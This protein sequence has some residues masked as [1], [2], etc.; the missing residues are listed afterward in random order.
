M[1]NVFTYFCGGGFLAG[2]LPRYAQNLTNYV[3]AKMISVHA[4]YDSGGCSE[5][6]KTAFRQVHGQ[7]FSPG[8]WLTGLVF[9]DAPPAENPFDDSLYHAT[10]ALDLCMN[11]AK[12]FTVPSGGN[13][14]DVV[15]NRIDE[16]KNLPRFRPSLARALTEMAAAIDADPALTAALGNMQTHKTS[17]GNL[18]ILY[19][20]HKYGK[21]LIAALRHSNRLLN[22]AEKTLAFPVGIDDCILT[23]QLADGRVIEGHHRIVCDASAYTA[24]IA[25]VE[26][27]TIAGGKA[28][29]PT[30]EALDAI[31]DTEL[32]YVMGGGSPF[33]S[34]LVHLLTDGV[35]PLLIEQVCRGKRFVY[36]VKPMVELQT[37]GLGVKDIFLVYEKSLQ[38]LEPELQIQH[39]ITDVVL[40]V[41]PQELLDRY[42][43]HVRLSL[44]GL[45]NAAGMDAL[46]KAG[47]DFGEINRIMR[48]DALMSEATLRKIETGELKPA[49]LSACLPMPVTAEDREFLAARRIRIH[50][51]D[52][53]GIWEGSIQYHPGAVI[54]FL[55]DMFGGSTLIENM[56]PL[57]R[58]LSEPRYDS[59]MRID[60]RVELP[61]GV[62]QVALIGETG[63]ARVAMAAELQAQFPDLSVTPSGRMTVSILK[64]G[65]DKT[66]PISYVYRNFD[67]LF[68][69]A[70]SNATL[71]VCD[72]DGTLYGLPNAAGLP[73]LDTSPF[74]ETVWK[75]LDAGDLL[76]VNTANGLYTT[77]E[78]LTRNGALPA[79]YYSQVLVAACGGAVL[80][81]IEEVKADA[82]KETETE[83]GTGTETDSE[84]VA[85]P[86]IR[87]VCDEEYIRSAKYIRRL[88]PGFD[89]GFKCVY[90]GDNPS[91]KGED[92]AAFEFV[93]RANSVLVPWRVIGLREAFLESLETIPVS[94]GPYL[95]ETVVG[96]QCVCIDF[97]G[98]YLRCR[99]MDFPSDGGQPLTLQSVDTQFTAEQKYCSHSNPFEVTALFTKKLQLDP[100]RNYPVG[101]SFSQPFTMPDPDNPRDL[102]MTLSA[103]GWNLDRYIGQNLYTLFQQAFDNA[104]CG[105]LDL[106]F[107]S[108]DIACA[109]LACM[110]ADFALIVGTGF[111]FSYK[112][113]DRRI[114]V[115]EAGEFMSPEMDL[116]DFDLYY[117]MAPIG[118][119]AA[120][121]M[122]AGK[123]LWDN[124]RIASQGQDE[125]EVTR[126]RIR[127]AGRHIGAMLGAMFF[128]DC[129]TGKIHIVADGTLIRNLSAMRAAITEEL[130]PYETVWNVMEDA[131][132]TGCGR[133]ALNDW[134][135]N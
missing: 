9:P 90:Y 122:I 29:T 66:L 71:R 7:G 52:R 79:R 5:W 70:A 44:G 95:P 57:N 120:E 42:L 100:C 28:P 91:P 99:L 84:T 46:L 130:S 10:M 89:S 127:R 134:F 128:R 121:K 38:K 15:K 97:G 1:Q 126:D 82:G 17:L 103:K 26:L 25:C 69:H 87:T 53:F 76:L 58:A 47:N 86:E 61:D 51:F 123:Y 27:K 56:E 88:T 35:A 124:I 18:L 22:G 14:S 41:I 93:G 50:D 98:T 113:P 68:P 114:H 21:N 102:R 78:R 20:Q 72:G 59:L 13:L 23:A 63:D 62:G 131:P 133:A 107:I 36:L 43:H 16:V 67:T 39:I 6:V 65:V 101:I 24:P 49:K 34:A 8:D 31:R 83:T 54:D 74:H 111:G 73:G 12:R 115:V 32:G 77:V 118:K 75:W 19:L 109:H 48:D 37:S 94:P 105:N 96:G 119:R 85:K 125:K 92:W 117:N 4:T 116:T 45:L 60:R 135:H 3:G 64:R 112:G 110:E 40:P 30:S 132:L 80:A 104:G 106:R 55:A 2:S 33:D 11:P 108:N 81:R 129:R